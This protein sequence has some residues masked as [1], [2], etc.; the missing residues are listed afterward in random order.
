MDI[1]RSLGITESLDRVIRLEVQIEQL[2]A[3]ISGRSFTTR[4]VADQH[5]YARKISDSIHKRMQEIQAHEKTLRAHPIE[6]RRAIEMKLENLYSNFNNLETD[7]E[8]EKS[9]KTIEK[10]TKI[11]KTFNADNP[12]RFSQD[13]EEWALKDGDPYFI[14]DKALRHPVRVRTSSGPNEIQPLKLLIAIANNRI[15]QRREIVEN[16]TKQLETAPLDQ[17]DEILAKINTVNSEMT[18]LTRQIDYYQSRYLP[19]GAEEAPI[20][21]D[22]EDVPAPLLKALYFSDKTKDYMKL[23]TPVSVEI[24][25]DLHR[26]LKDETHSFSKNDY[27][28]QAGVISV[29]DQ[30]IVILQVR[31][32]DCIYMYMDPDSG[33]VQLREESLESVKIYPQDEGQDLVKIVPYRGMTKSRLCHKFHVR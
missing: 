23:N 4:P 2:T 21:L 15:E 19:K 6:Y 32:K 11:L 20:S 1:P 27:R 5:T 31:S 14:R 16:L 24:D 28:A 3:Q 9:L 13:V 25:C 18:S 12:I 30:P 26:K 33:R 22:R 29:S 17:R 10:L 8:M 7:P